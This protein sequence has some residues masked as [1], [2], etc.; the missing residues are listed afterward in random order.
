MTAS[1]EQVG[2]IEQ[3][4]ILHAHVRLVIPHPSLTQNLQSVLFSQCPLDQLQQQFLHVLLRGILG[5]EELVN[6]VGAK[7]TRQGA[8]QE[9]L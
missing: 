5:E 6:A 2:K 7:D 4:P 1:P 8:F 9:V 3:S